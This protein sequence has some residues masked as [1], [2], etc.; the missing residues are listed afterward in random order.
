MSKL[1]LNTDEITELWSMQPSGPGKRLSK[2]VL[3]T[4]WLPILLLLPLLP[5]NFDKNTIIVYIASTI[6]FLAFGLITAAVCAPWKHRR[7]LWIKKSTLATLLFIGFNSISIIFL[8]LTM[9]AMALAVT[10]DIP[11]PDAILQIIQVV[12]VLVLIASLL[13]APYIIRRQIVARHSSISKTYHLPV[14]LGAGPGLGVFLGSILTRTSYALPVIVI[15]STFGALLLAPFGML[16]LYEAF[17]LTLN[18]NKKP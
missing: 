7:K 5:L 8:S 1:F 9:L 4:L 18:W 12:Y 2:Q 6:I 11:S 13:S 17:A 14:I 16:K 3:G 15:T 10:K